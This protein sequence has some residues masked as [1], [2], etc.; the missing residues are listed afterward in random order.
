MIG[1]YSSGPIDKPGIGRGKQFHAKREAFSQGD[2]LPNK[3]KLGASFQCK[4]SIGRRYLA[5]QHGE[6]MLSILMA[7][8][9]IGD[10]V[11]VKGKIGQ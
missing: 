7:A 5:G 8:D 1:T 2:L 4:G 11:A 9:K 10:V 3:G 6:L